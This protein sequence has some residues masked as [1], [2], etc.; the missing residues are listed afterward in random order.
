MRGNGNESLDFRTG[1]ADSL[2]QEIA[3][4]LAA[5]AQTGEPSAIDLRSL[6]MT[7]TDRAELEERLGQG[8]IAAALVVAGRSE[9]WETRYSGV[10]WVRHFGAD[11]K[12]AAERIEI[13]QV[14]EILLTHA[15]DIAA[16][17]A[18]LHADLVTMMGSARESAEHV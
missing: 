11:E 3:R 10:W 8:D 17:S 16:A 9:V 6:P 7:A 1:M 13:T 15:D 12:I 18:R 5:L 4:L 2:M 14:P